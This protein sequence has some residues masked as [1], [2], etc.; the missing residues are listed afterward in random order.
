M[1]RKID[2]SPSLAGRKLARLPC[3][4]RRA[5][6]AASLITSDE[7]SPCRGAVRGNYRLR[8]ARAVRRSVTWAG[9]APAAPS[10]LAIVSFAIRAASISP[11]SSAAC[12]SPARWARSAARG[13]AGFAGESQ[14]RRPSAY[15]SALAAEVLEATPTL[16]LR[17]SADLSV[18]GRVRIPLGTPQNI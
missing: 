18:W 4:P 7:G 17:I 11:A 1:P 2:R 16:L 12:M 15:L 8:R 13:F 6:S 3:V 14:G 5:S 10:S 9:S